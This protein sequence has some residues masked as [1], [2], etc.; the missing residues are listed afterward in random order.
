MEAVYH[1]LAAGSTGS[2][3]ALIRRYG[4]RYRTAKNHAAL[5]K[6]LRNISELI[7]LGVLNKEAGRELERQRYYGVLEI[8]RRVPR[9]ASEDELHLLLS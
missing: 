5:D 3:T 6:L 4:Y 8:T 1:E 7:T 2:A 9:D